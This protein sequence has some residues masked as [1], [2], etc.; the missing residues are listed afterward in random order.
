MVDRISAQLFALLA[1][2]GH[3]YGL[4]R[5]FKAS[6][7][8]LGGGRALAS[9]PRSAV[10]SN[11]GWGMLVDRLAPLGILLDGQAEQLYQQSELLHFAV[12]GSPLLLQ[13]EPWV[14]RNEDCRGKVYFEAGARASRALWLGRAAPDNRLPVFV[15]YK[16]QPHQPVIITRYAGLPLADKASLSAALEASWQG[17]PNAWSSALAA[18]ITPLAA[19]L[20]TASQQLLEV[21]EEGNP[22]SSVDLNLYPLAYP[23]ARLAPAL[24]HI[25]ESL[26]EI[27][28]EPL[29]GC[30]DAIAQQ[31]LGHLAWGSDRTG[32]P[33]ISCYYGLQELAGGEVVG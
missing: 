32:K 24:S 10:E 9:V 13:R 7:G 29:R 17:L 23:V 3:R 4:E 18:L 2:F 8:Q 12:E 27:A 19:L 25:L 14:Q 20:P 22:R 33:F 5:S 31:P 6:S 1:E 16:W 11:G 15:A 21:T 30:L 26:C 28:P